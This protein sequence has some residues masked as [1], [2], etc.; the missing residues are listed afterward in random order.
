MG[1]PC[2][3]RATGE[4]VRRW[5]AGPD[6][7]ILG[8]RARPEIA[9]GSSVFAQQESVGGQLEG[10]TMERT[11]SWVRVLEI[12]WRG[13]PQ[14]RTER[15]GSL[16]IRCHS[17]PPSVHPFR[18]LTTRMQRSRETELPA[19][20]LAQWLRKAGLQLRCVSDIPPTDAALGAEDP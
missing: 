3:V 7:C 15:P 6:P 1:S 8:A 16:Q 13:A 12:G 20:G 18:S 9:V 17:W 2:P 10:V 14:A 4:P 11:R 5:S 19:Q